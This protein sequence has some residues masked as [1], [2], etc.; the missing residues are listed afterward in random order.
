MI[1]N[2]SLRQYERQKRIEAERCIK[3][4]AKL[5]SPVIDVSF[6]LGYDWYAICTV[7]LMILITVLG[8]YSLT[9]TG[10]FRVFIV[11]N[12]AKPHSFLIQNRAAYFKKFRASRQLVS[13]SLTLGIANEVKP[14]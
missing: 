11:E 9:G 12:Y 10:P 7:Y 6:A 3:S 5:I 13:L 8:P 2:D 1:K 4:A 14:H